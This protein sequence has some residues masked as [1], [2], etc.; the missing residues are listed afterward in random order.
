MAARQQAVPEETGQPREH[1]VVEGLGGWPREEVVVI[2]AVRGRRQRRRQQRRAR[3]RRLAATVGL[4]VQR[5][6]DAP[7][8]AHPLDES[9]EPLALCDVGAAARLAKAPDVALEDEPAPRLK[10]VAGRVRPGLDR[11]HRAV[12]IEAQH[13]RED[14]LAA[15]EPRRSRHGGR[16]DRANAPSGLGDNSH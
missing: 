11:H 15:V 13:R 14:G 9:V 2:L 8:L 5:D 4:L 6:R 3:R 16:E 1:R 12:M 7:V 10:V